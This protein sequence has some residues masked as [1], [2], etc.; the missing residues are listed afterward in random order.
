MKTV[1]TFAEEEDQNIFSRVMESH[2]KNDSAN[3]KMLYYLS[4][5]FKYPKDFKS[6]LYITQILQGMAIKSGVE[7]WRRHRGRCM[8]TLYWQINDNWPVASW[9]SIDY[10]GRW[11][12]LHYM[13]RKFYAPVAAS[14]QKKGNEWSVH[15]ENE[16]LETQSCEVVLRVRDMQFQVLQEWK[17]EGSVDKLSSKELLTIIM[18]EE[19]M[20]C[21]QAFVEAE[22]VLANGERLVETEVFIPYKHMDLIEPELEIEVRE[23]DSCY[24]ILIG[25]DVFT[26]FVELDFDDA[27]VIFSD[28]F[29][30][31]SNKEPVTIILDKKDIVHGSFQDVADLMERLVVTTV[32]DTF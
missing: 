31:I 15:L 6:L 8:G 19:F 7:H 12:A 13:A 5:N 4:E 11:K 27:D 24:E 23:Q 22:V 3:G 18:P 14:I 1:R 17:A 20:C 2:Q 26:P 21:P 16:S 9:A 30:T 25:S 28:N 32:T 29:I 10:Y